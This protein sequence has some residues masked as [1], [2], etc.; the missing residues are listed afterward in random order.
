M[1]ISTKRI[2][3]EDDIKRVR[4]EKQRLEN[5]NMNQ[6]ARTIAD[7]SIIPVE[8]E[9]FVQQYYQVKQFYEQAKAAGR[10][11]DVKSSEL[12]LKEL[13]QTIKN[14]TRK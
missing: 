14:V 1:T 7:L 6:F 4:D 12:K 3:S 2:P 13:E 8:L 5:E 9:P 11:D 10:Y